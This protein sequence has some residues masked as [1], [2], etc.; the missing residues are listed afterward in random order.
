MS[1]ISLAKSIVYGPRN[2][3]GNMSSTYRSTIY[4]FYK[5]EEYFTSSYLVRN[6]SGTTRIISGSCF[7]IA[8]VA[9]ISYTKVIVT[10][11]ELL[12]YIR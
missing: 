9:R 4:Y 3:S 6:I 7:L 12:Y 5:P 11:P 8:L 2:I 1:G 10:S